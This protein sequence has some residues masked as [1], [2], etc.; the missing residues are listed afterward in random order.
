MSV[1]YPGFLYA[2]TVAAGGI[3]GY[4]KAGSIPSL[5]AGLIFG[6][7][8]AIGAYQTTQDPM[9]YGVQLAA[10]SILA[11]VMGLRFYKS[12]KIMPAGVVTLLSVGI[13]ARIGLRALGSGPT[14]Y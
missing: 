2:G 11:G 7:A 10:S 12:G 6:T 8:L 3:M 9:R 13:I 14:K 4:V 1:D 5:A